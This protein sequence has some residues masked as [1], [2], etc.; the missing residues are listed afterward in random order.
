MSESMPLCKLMVP[1]DRCA[2]ALHNNFP[3]D[4]Q[5][6]QESV[7]S[8]AVRSPT[9]LGKTSNPEAQVTSVGGGWS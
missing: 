7:H 6:K 8:V 2:P 4:S 3:F 9:V 1:E 5:S